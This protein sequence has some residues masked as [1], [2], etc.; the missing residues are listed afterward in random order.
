MI[1]KKIE[2]ITEADLQA[3]ID[4][5]VLEG[6]TIEYKRELPTNADSGKKEFLA[7]VTS[8]ANTSGGDLLFGIEE[9][10]ASHEPRSLIGIEVDNIDNENI[11]IGSNL[12]YSQLIPRRNKHNYPLMQNCLLL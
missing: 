5:K 12:H 9:D 4:N 1:N 6:K 2:D 3:L 11:S 7:D 8:F 10:H